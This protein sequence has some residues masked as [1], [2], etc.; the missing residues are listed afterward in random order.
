MKKRIFTLLF[1]LAFLGAFHQLKSQTDVLH[2]RFELN[3]F[4]EH[5]SIQGLATIRL[6]PKTDMSSVALDLKNINK[7]KGMMVLSVADTAGRSLNFEHK[8]DK[9]NIFQSVRKGDT[10]TFHI[11]YKGIPADGLIISKNKY[12]KRTFFGDNWPN[13]A[14]HWLPCH[15]HPSDKA[16]VEFVITA[17]DHY[18]VISNGILWE[19]SQLSGK[20]K[21]SHWK[22]D[23][24]LPTKVMV[25]GVAEFAVQFSGFVKNCIPV[26]SWVF[27]ENKAEGFYDYAQAV[28]VL[29]WFIRYIGPY[30]Y[31]KLANVQSKTIFGGMENASC[32]FYHENSVNGRRAEEDLLAHEIAHQWFGNMVTEKSFAH[33]WLSEG[34]A[35]YFTHLYL[36]QKYGADTLK[37]R[38]REDRN[39]VLAFGKRNTRPVVDS[40]PQ[41][42]SLLNANSYQKGSWILHMLR[43]ELGD[44]VF[45]KSIRD[46]YAKYAGRN[47]ETADLQ[48][49]FEFHSGKKLDSFFRQWLFTPE[50]PVILIS[51][52]YEVSKKRVSVTVEQKQNTLFTFPLDMALKTKNHKEKMHC[53]QITKRNETFY[54]PVSEAV[55]SLLPDFNVS[56]LAEIS[57]VQQN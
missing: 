49:I 8:L 37:K 36:E 46:F 31:K 44:T 17:P 52:R 2:Y 15:D 1:T 51:W 11:R 4:D 42:M 24:P 22:E 38:M 47:A 48:N 32:I 30:A 14:H 28:E 7:G 5:D 26:S 10:T 12:G 6:L 50:N 27:P 41:L 33:L 18:K 29:E 57:V 34:F 16:S 19:E 56:L 43:R 21:L 40:T 39:T 45:R 25:I 23:V 53:L 20:R 9:I 55:V 35:T 54:I 13:R 3:L